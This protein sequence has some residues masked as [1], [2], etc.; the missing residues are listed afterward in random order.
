[1]DYGEAKEGE[2]WFIYDIQLK[3]ELFKSILPEQLVG[4]WFRADNAQW[5]I[6]LFDSVA[7]YK[8]Q[9]WQYR[10]YSEKDG[11]GKIV[12]KH[13]KKSITIYSKTINDSV[14]MFGEVAA[15]FSK[16]TREPDEKVIPAETEIYKVPIFKMDTV[17]YCGYIKGFRSNILQKTGMVSVVNVFT[18]QNVPHLLK[19]AD[20]GSFNVKFV[21]SNPQLIMVNIFSN[22]ELIFIEP[23]K[24]IFHLIDNNNEGNPNLY[25][26]EMARINADIDKL[27]YTNALMYFG[28][29]E[30][31]FTYSPKEFEEYLMSFYAKSLSEIDKIRQKHQISDKA[32]Q[33]WKMQLDYGYVDLSI[34]YARKKYKLG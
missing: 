11:L 19:I 7:I 25:M 8:C 26:G 27:K 18:G 34:C 28:L 5:E 2:N 24:S 3:S 23:G 20:D 4:H 33:I 30:N 10:Q 29:E 22:N 17:T 13:G 21:H 9:V 16:Y 6:S 14:C 31:I 12:L 32:Y 15:K 1:M